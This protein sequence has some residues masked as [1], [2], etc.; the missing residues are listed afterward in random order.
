MK[1]AI[2]IFCI[3]TYTFVFAQQKYTIS[4]VVKDKNSLETVIGVNIYI[5]EIS[6]GVSTNEYGYYSLTIPEGTYNLTISFL[7]FKKISK[8]IDLNSDQRIEFLLEEDATSL[9]EIVLKENTSLAN[10]SS[11][12]MSVIKMPIQTIKNMP[13]V[14]GEVDIIKS[15]QLLPGVSNAGEGASGFN[16]RGGAADQNL[17][18]LD[19]AIIYNAS[20]LFG[21]FSVFN[22]DAIKDIK[23]YKGG[24]PA[25]YGGRVSSV[26]DVHQ[27]DGNKNEF[28]VNG[29]IGLISSRLLLEGPLD[30]DQK[31]SFLIAGRGSYA[32]LFLK[33]AN[34]PNS[35]YFYDLNTKISYNFN[36]KNSLFLSGYFGRDIFQISD[37]FNNSYGNTTV[38]LRWNHLFNDQIFSN[39]SL[40]YSD[41]NYSLSINSINFDWLSNINNYNIKYDL[42]Y[43]AGERSK[44]QFGVN[45]LYYDFNPGEITATDESSTVNDEKLDNKYAFESAVYT[46][47][48]HEITKG[49]RVILGVRFSMF[50]RLGEQSVALYNNDQPVV[51]NENIG[52]YESASPIGVEEFGGGEVIA[53]FNNFE[54]RLG[55]SYQINNNS[56]FKASYNQMVQY[57]HLISNTNSPTPLDVWAPS[58][59]YILPQLLDQ[60]NM[61]YFINFKENQFTLE[62]EIFYK[63]TKNRLD[64]IDGANLIANN[65]IETEILS[66][67]ARSYGIEFLL[68]KNLGNFT[69]WFAYT[70]SRSEQRVIGRTSFET[71]INNGNW[72]NTGYDKLHDISIIGQYAYS[73]KW[74]FGANFVYQT[75]RA[76][77]Y[78]TGYYVYEDLNI[79][80]YTGRNENNLPAYHHLDISAT[81]H[82]NQKKGRKWKSEWVFSIY[83]VYARKNAASITFKQSDETLKNEAVKLSIFG[84]VPSV[85][86]NF[87]F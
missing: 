32:H 51:F 46:D 29:G 44:M 13:V 16:V 82:P 63:K 10:I 26:L 74:N 65:I 87:K 12:E 36:D 80:L 22:V 33:M 59:K 55:M 25:K 21:F 18:L 11:P 20:H 60:Y 50:H 8:I 19:E 4:G 30:K 77:T 5:P 68:K 75:G 83:N 48:E 43:F 40:I 27:K 84:I 14:L 47:F 56:S 62:T 53:S 31:S 81:L 1:K 57:I 58:G 42:T 72:Y 69:G 64:Y 66:G 7:G 45:G 71:G 41:Y 85:T 37:S 35:A 70:L 78:P 34:E 24:V 54:P 9:D 3:F 67:D 61:G 23:L 79:P 38:N 28:H 49:F 52:I 6:K 86:Y 73:K 76:T 15:I 17:I 2:L 39:L